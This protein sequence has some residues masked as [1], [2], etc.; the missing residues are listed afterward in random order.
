MAYEDKFIV[1]VGLF[2]KTLTRKREAIRT[3]HRALRKGGVGSHG[4]VV[5]KEP[6]GQ[7]TLIYQAEFNYRQG[8]PALI[9][10]EL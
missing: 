5:Q 1:A 7:T 4:S 8:R 6:D 10:H 3:L 2:S 9:V